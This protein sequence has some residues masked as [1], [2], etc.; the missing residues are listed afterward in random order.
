MLELVR[1]KSGES[2]VNAQTGGAQTAPAVAMLAGGGHVVVWTDASQTGGDASG[3]SVKAQ[4]FDAAGAKVGGELLVN[5]FTEGSQS[6][7]VVAGLASGGFVVTWTHGEDDVALGGDGSESSIKGQMFTGAGARL[8]GEFRVNVGSSWI[9]EDSHVFALPGGGFAVSWSDLGVNNVFTR[10]Y[11]SNGSTSGE[12][13]LASNGRQ[14]NQNGPTGAA[15]G[16]DRFVVAWSHQDIDGNF[17]HGVY[18]QIFDY[19]G[20]RLSAE[21]SLST[22]IA[23]I[24][25]APDMAALAGGGFV[26]VWESGE[27]DYSVKAQ[28]FGSD[29]AR[30]G[31]E[32]LVSS[33][34]SQVTSISVTALA[35]GGFLV[36][37][38][39][40]SSSVWSARGQLFD[41]EGNRVGA[42]FQINTEPVPFDSRVD[43]VA[44][45]SGD[46]AAVWTNEAGGNAA[47][48]GIKSQI[49]LLPTVGTPG[50]DSIGGTSGDDSIAGLGGDDS[51]AGGAGADLLEGDG[52][53]DILDG[54]AGAD[55]MSGGL[56]GDIYYVDHEG[57]L[58]EEYAGEGTDEIRTSLDSYSLSGGNVEKLSATTNGP[59]D[60]RGGGG[61]NVVTGGGGNDLLRLND[62]GDDTASGGGG[63]D[64][65]YF[66]GAFT[67]ADIADG[68]EGRDVLVLQGNYTLTL[69]AGNLTGVESLSLQS[70][71][72]TTW[73]DVANNFYDYSLTTN[74][75]NVA[76][77]QQ[78]IVNGQTLRAGE[79]F[80][81]DGSAETD[82]YFL[83]Y[84]GHGVDTLKGG[85]GNDAF[86]FEGVRWGAG[87]TVDGGAGRDAL[88]ISSGSGINHFDFGANALTGIES[89]SLNNR[90]TTDPTQKPS[91]ELVLANGNVAPGATLIVNGSSLAD[92]SQTVGVDGS[93][94]HD[95]NLILFGGFG[96]DTLRGGDGA[97][98]FQGGEGVDMLT[99]GAGADIF[100]YAGQYDATAQLPDRIL[101]FASGVDKIDLTRIDA[102]LFAAG[103]QAFHW[104]GSAAFGGAGAASAGELRA[105]DFNGSW[106]V[107]G[108][109]DGNGAADLV[110]QLTTPAAPPVQGDFLL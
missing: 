65:L 75:A 57:D 21:F 36:S 68:G 55:S 72:R 48:L 82:G 28:I 64:V 94:V 38:M 2:Y 70:G 105:Y 110:I 6:Q 32:R 102:D 91:Y 3:T 96:N 89:I 23:G 18:G 24:Q 20:N 78:L 53:D 27:A 31:P 108:D 5:S 1:K 12:D 15:L 62:G 40:L 50:P 10:V 71:S 84:G 52:G 35:W 86:F 29:G 56:G 45:A 69:S 33:P 26:A 100:R 85:A 41:G 4:L 8:G 39:N 44:L 17:D 98:L 7:P 74:N 34:G 107:E 22:V 13:I 25:A 79:D 60:L 73:G 14:G 103:D 43:V 97:D 30:I 77:G 9:Q 99:G 87:D 104:I 101:D 19:A 66:G 67:G 92:R 46:V 63:S 47:Q 81:F 61:D 54:G 90:Y 37:W 51:I 49:L 76:A 83:V 58:V 93:A 95:G 106:F 109:M 42:E 59:H 16:A 11:D 80:S 88:I